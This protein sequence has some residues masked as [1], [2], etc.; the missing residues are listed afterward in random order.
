MYDAGVDIIF[1]AAGRAGLGVFDSV[2]DKNTTSS[3][4]LWCIGVDSP[5]MYYGTA[6]P[7]ADPV[8]GPTLCL[9]SMLKRVDIAVYTI[10][11]DWVVDATWNTGYDLL[12][13]FNLA[14]DGVGYEVNEDLLTLD[15]AIIS[16]VED[17]KAEIVAGNI[18]VPSEIYW[19]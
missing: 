11:E 2:K 18:V 15:P 5:Q 1:A 4:P 8:V 7:D 17:F 12:Y 13:T 6:D 3:E 9:T 16:A 19:T 14:N 10:I